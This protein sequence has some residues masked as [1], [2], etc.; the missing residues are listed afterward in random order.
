MKVVGKK[1]IVRANVAGVHAGVVKSF[2]PKTQTVVLANAY[3]L[4]RFY[5]R[6]K[7]GSISDVAANGLK[8]DGGHSIGA[9]LASVVI[10]N[11][12]G[13]ELAEMTNAAYESLEDWK[14]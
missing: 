14:N 2:D 13:L 1:M 12:A 11:P 9:K 3:R 5:T 10:T 6:D 7:S 8:P 4:W